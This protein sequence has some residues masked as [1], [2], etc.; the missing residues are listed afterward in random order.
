MET[1]S[2][3]RKWT[4]G[5]WIGGTWEGDD[6][7]EV[8]DDNLMLVA[9]TK[10]EA[11]AHLIAAAPDLYEALEYMR[12]AGCPDCNGDCASANPQVAAC[13]MKRAAAAL[14]KARG[15]K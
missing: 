13:P 8:L 12:D 4:P 2:N 15:E 9:R 11:N 1:R 5:P 7:C 3:E 14:A 10:T 6:T